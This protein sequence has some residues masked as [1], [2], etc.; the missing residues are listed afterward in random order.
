MAARA[1]AAHQ[2]EVLSTL[3]FCI[4]CLVLIVALA[5]LP[6]R[7]WWSQRQALNHAEDLR[8]DLLYER[9]QLEAQL[10]ILQTDAEV[11]RLAGPTTTSSTPG[12][13]VSA[14]CPPA[15]SPHQPGLTTPN[16]RRRRT[17]QR[18]AKRTRRLS[19]S[20]GPNSVVS[21]NPREV[22]TSGST[23]PSTR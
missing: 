23:P 15:N 20:S 10:A 9:A 4:V 13:R 5:V 2:R 19:A 6:A 22:R 16:R 14:S 3:A 12:K 1:S 11:E 17:V 21:P 7:T 18:R 8:A